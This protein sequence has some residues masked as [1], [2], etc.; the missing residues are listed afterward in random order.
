[1][2]WA[3]SSPWLLWFLAVTL[4]LNAL[5]YISTG[6][7]RGTTSCLFRYFY[8]SLICTH[9][10]DWNGTFWVYHVKVTWLQVWAFFINLIFFLTEFTTFHLKEQPRKYFVTSLK[11]FF[12]LPV[13]HFFHLDK[14]HILHLF[15]TALRKLLKKPQNWRT[16]SLMGKHTLLWFNFKNCF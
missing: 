12:H 2:L 1:M 10:G 6:K 5:K 13:E 16:S 9:Q 8:A 4:L 11:Y 3:P 15:N 14:M 7:E